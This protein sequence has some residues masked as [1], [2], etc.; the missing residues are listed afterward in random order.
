VS[1]SRSILIFE[2]LLASP[3]AWRDASVSMQ[4]ESISML[5]ALVHDFARLPDVRPTVLIASDAMAMF[6]ELAGLPQCI[7]ML[8]LESDPSEWL[9]CR[10]CNPDNFDATLI[11]AP[12]CH[13][14]LVQLLRQLQTDDR[15][16]KIRNINLDW[17]LAEIFSDKLLTFQ[18]LQQH[19]LA[20]PATIAISR[21]KRDALLSARNCQH[22]ILDGE[23]LPQSSGLGVLKPR[24]GVGCEGVSFIQLPG[25][26]FSTTEITDDGDRNW[27]LQS[28]VPGRACSVGLVG[29]RG[30]RPT[31]IL[32]PA[33]QT[34][35]LRNGS[36]VYCGGRIPSDPE[37]QNAIMPLA[38]KL[39][40]AL[41]E[42]SGY[43]GVDV[44]VE[45]SS[46]SKLKATV[47]ELNP[48]LCTSY[49][50]YRQATNCNLAALMFSGHS[51]TA[52]SW[53]SQTIEFEAN[54]RILSSP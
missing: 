26:N 54:G 16:R 42:F 10:N 17:Q 2:Y 39:A 48:R 36:P 38:E 9:N 46:N 50:G 22:F 52:L 28:Y 32:P 20:T 53:H 14:I 34:L 6:R 8:E 33:I 51:K 3:G 13:G 47:I 18:W 4:R 27:L 23:T 12:E 5:A 7:E 37:L 41:G 24:D 21:E 43:L 25:E 30:F 45:Q 1:A 40:S 35:Q 49:V 15:W 44:V 31:T 11:I 19:E 29:G